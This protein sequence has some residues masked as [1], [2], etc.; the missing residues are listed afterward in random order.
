[1]SVYCAEVLSPRQQ[2]KALLIT[3]KPEGF[4]LERLGEDGMLEH[5]TQHETLDDA[6]YEAYAQY[7]RISEWRFCPDDVDPLDYLRTR[8]ES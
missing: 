2:V 6:M 1:M 5:R 4:F 8:S 3:E 7:G